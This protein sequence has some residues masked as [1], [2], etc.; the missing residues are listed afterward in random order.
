MWHLTACKF[1]VSLSF[2]NWIKNEIIFYFLYRVSAISVVCRCSSLSTLLKSSIRNIKENKIKTNSVTFLPTQNCDFFT[3]D[4]LSYNPFGHVCPAKIRSACT[5]AHMIRI[6]TGRILDSRGCKVSS[7]GQR[8]LW[9]DCANAQA[10][11]SLRWAHMS[12]GRCSHVE[13]YIWNLLYIDTNLT[14]R[15]HAYSNIL[16]I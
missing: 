1:S 11:L 15:K 8:R 12:D 7:C 5:F 13:A 3:C 6:W 14:L 2:L 16:K 9:S 10:D 4:F